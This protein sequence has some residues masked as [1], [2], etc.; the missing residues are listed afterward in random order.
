MSLHGLTTIG[1]GGKMNSEVSD[2][3]PKSLVQQ[4]WKHPKKQ[5]V[6]FPAHKTGM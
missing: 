2:S 1:F 3:A 6:H 5:P 4:R